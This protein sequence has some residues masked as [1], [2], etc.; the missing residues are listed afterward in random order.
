MICIL[1]M[2][3]YFSTCGANEFRVIIETRW[4]K[5]QSKPTEPEQTWLIPQ[6]SR[7][8]WGD[9]REFNKVNLVREMIRYNPGIN[10]KKDEKCLTNLLPNDF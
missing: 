9:S 3:L 1:F 2:L 10:N 8:A 4:K 6:P 5:L 7:S